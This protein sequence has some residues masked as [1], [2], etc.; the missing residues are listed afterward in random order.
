MRDIQD[1]A[2][3]KI[4][5]ASPDTIR[6]WS[7]GEVK[8]P[9]TINYRTLRPEKDG[10]FCERIFGTTKEWE[11]YCGKFKS[12]RYKGVI[13]DRCGVEVTHFKVRRE[14]T[15][16][17]ELAAPVSHIW[18]Y[19]SVPSRMGLLLDMQ[20]AQLRA[21]L[22]YEKYIVIDAGD[23][24]LKKMQL[25]T[26]DEYI[27]ARERYGETFTADMGAEAIKTLLDNI[28]LD[29]L[30]AELR[31]KMIEKGSKSDKRLLKRIEIV[32]NFRSS[33]NKAS[34]MILDVIPVIPPELR[35]MVQLD[36]GRFATSDLNDLYRRVINRNNR[37]KR[38]QQLSA[39]DI[40]IRNEKRM[41]Q[42][43]VDSLFDNSKRKRVVK[44]AS[45]RPLKSIS[46]M[47][48]GKQGR[49]RQNL[50]GKRVDY[51]GRSVIVVGPELKLWQCGL[52]TKM[53]LELFKPFIMKKLVDKDVVFNIKKAK[54]LVESEAPEVFSI[55][56]E[57]VREHPVML[58]RA[59]TLHRLGILAFEPVLV[60]GKALKLHPLACK[61]F[62]ADFDG[63]QMAIH[64]PLTQAAQME[65]WT[66]MLS[67][68]NLLDP[69]NGNTIVAPSQDMVLGIYY[70]TSV[71]P[72]AKGTGKRFSSPDEVRLAAESGAIEWQ[73][74]IKVN[75]PKDS[76]KEGEFKAGDLIETTAG[77]LRF[78]EAM[79]DGV[80]YVNE[81]M[82]D[83]KLKAM[84]EDVYHTQGPWLTIQMLDAI[85]SVGYKNATF[86][87]ATLSMDDILVPAE[88]KEMVDKANKEVEKIV[89]DYSKGVITGEERYNRVC[90]I[91]AR[92]ND[93]LTDLMMKNLASHKDGFNTIYMMATSGARGSKKQISQLAAMRGLMAKPSGEII[94]LPIRSNFKEGLS[95]IEYFISTNGARK[96]L[97]DTALKTADA[98]YMTRRL[99]DVAQDVV[100]NDED[101]G[102]IN[103]I[104]YAAIK[105]GDEIV[106]HLADRIVGHYTIERVV[107]PITGDLI[108]DV[109][110]YITPELAKKIED[111]GVEKVKL[112]TVLTCEAQHGICIKCY[113]QNLARNK[114][115][116]IGE[117]VGIIAAQSIGQPGTQLTLR[118]F[119]SGGTADKAT[120]DNR[121]VLNFN[122]IINDVQG[123]HVEMDDGSWLFTRKGFMKVIR[124]LD[125][126]K[127]ENGDDLKVQD[128]VS[129]LKDSVLLVRKGKEVTASASGK[130]IIKDNVL[131]LVNK[132]V[133]V[134][135]SNG[136]TIHIK[137]GDV[138]EA[139]KALGTFDQY[140]DPIIAES[141]GYVHFEDVI[142]GSTLAE[143]VDMQTGKTERTITDLH[144]DVKQPRILVTDEAGN[145]MGSYYLP[146]GA[147][148]QVEDTQQ[149]K[150]GDTLAK[151]PKEAAKTNDITGGIPRVTELFEARKPKNPCVLA[152]ISGT[153]KFKGISKAKRIIAVEDEFGN[154]FEH[155][156]PT[157]KHML[158]RDGDK[159]EAGEQLCDGAP[160]PSD[161]LNILGENA[162]QNYLMDEIQSVYRAQGVSIND[163]HIGVIVRQM[164]RKVEIVAVGD[165]KFIYGQQ[166][167][168]YKFHEENRRVVSE[169]G[170]P[171][172]ARP[173]FQGIT[174]AALNVDSFLSAAS[175]QETTRV[176]TNAAISGSTDGL[177]GIKENVAIGHM[178]PAGTGIKNYKN[179]KL[180]DESDTDLD[181]QMD[182]ILERRRQE[183]ELEMNRVE[184]PVFEADE[185]D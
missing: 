42:E 117:A 170:Q 56:D 166:V 50:L 184:E 64:V 96:G 16:H 51:S 6:A 155:L 86:F 9:E 174:K 82:G 23:T 74:A 46:D 79:P 137:A 29:A 121:I 103:G 26:E 93:E 11:C 22:Y 108:C 163:K 125:S 149:I 183:K 110:E 5:L 45:N 33:G 43:A 85:K 88:K 15:G 156:V 48:K 70:M 40:I 27:E 161:I 99:V 25:L 134:E 185:Q 66:L 102:T 111:A 53:A 128:G 179:I 3:V 54:M 83:K 127:L 57:V 76:F 35:P 144:L 75:A 8:K 118:T 12:I 17:I 131:Y 147:V 13:C 143:K 32:E 130:V 52:P 162:L 80:R 160:N 168:K 165:T 145:E 58:N 182:E 106:V 31:A 177:H 122:A 136:S 18:Y 60:E 124:I 153:V 20:V 94:E 159:V 37:L 65:C 133:K 141:N 101:C 61:S 1:F 87:G 138:V 77:R 71:K 55:L 14:R 47:I 123:T 115:V 105:D 109:N 63:D 97:S 2:S 164:L 73:A 104:D 95:V 150:A 62:N 172:V 4:K 114:I 84:I 67:A 152:R 28:D 178:I 120:E 81:L 30:A 19:R 146:A 176:L 78:N 59:P 68:R 132:E 139:G 91:W 154:V 142:L 129:L 98:G 90:D 181:V 72:G 135:I 38:L 112:R 44:G 119:H 49:F 157:Q 39:P 36:G 158:V 169:G 34:W 180:F 92:T 69:A 126:V 41:L 100:V 173:M 171:A 151:M 107:H 24:D 175:F 148:L 116:E 113:G 89:N 10:L 7:Y 167:D 140:S 21:V